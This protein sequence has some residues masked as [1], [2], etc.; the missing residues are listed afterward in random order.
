MNAR[1]ESVGHTGV[2]R[3]GKDAH[4][5]QVAGGLGRV[6]PN[7]TVHC[8][9]RTGATCTRSHREEQEKRA[10]NARKQTGC[11]GGCDKF[12]EKASYACVCVCVR[13]LRNETSS[14]TSVTAQDALSSLRG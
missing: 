11:P 1:I 6:E 5:R 3:L 14:A 9:N 8:E 7:M 10:A 4:A 13:S 12:E 2:G